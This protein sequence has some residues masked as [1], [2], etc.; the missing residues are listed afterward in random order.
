[1]HEQTAFFPVD[2]DSTLKWFINILI[3]YSNGIIK[4][5]GAPYGTPLCH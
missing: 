5:R 3:M 1:M 2:I 4:K